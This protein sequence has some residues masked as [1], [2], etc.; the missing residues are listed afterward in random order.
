MVPVTAACLR[1]SIQ[2]PAQASSARLIQAVQESVA[3]SEQWVAVSVPVSLPE[4]P[5][6]VACSAAAGASAQAR[7]A[8]PVRSVA[9]ALE[10]VPVVLGQHRVQVQADALAAR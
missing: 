1:P 4:V 8:Q 10:R 6:S 5:H 2:D 7:A 9:S 3:E